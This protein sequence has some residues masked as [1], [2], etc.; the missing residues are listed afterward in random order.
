MSWSKARHKGQTEFVRS[1]C[2]SNC[3]FCILIFFQF[4]IYKL[5]IFNER[6]KMFSKKLVLR[7]ICTYQDFQ[8]NQAMSQ[9]NAKNGLCSHPWPQKN[10]VW[11]LWFAAI[12]FNIYWSTIFFTMYWSASDFEFKFQFQTS[13]LQSL[14]DLSPWIKTEN[15]GTKSKITTRGWKLTLLC[16]IGHVE[17][18][19][20][21]GKCLSAQQMS[22]FQLFAPDC[23]VNNNK[24]WS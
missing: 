1:V 23:K 4:K 14:N 24:N 22:S 19:A 10:K 9:Q 15:L 20:K 11:N 3:P 21:S 8:K 12:F 5:F 17:D 2:P 6:Q 16:I 18:Q 13:C 7:N